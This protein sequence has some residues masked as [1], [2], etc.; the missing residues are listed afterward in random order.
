MF[1]S[2]FHLSS[3]L[4]FQRR[5]RKKGEWRVSGGGFFTNAINCNKKD[6][7]SKGGSGVDWS[8]HQIELVIL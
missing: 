4:G 8:M 6:V 3:R 7:F 5:K 2:H 1:C